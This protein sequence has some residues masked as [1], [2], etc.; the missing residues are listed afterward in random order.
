MKPLA[1]K[2]IM[3]LCGTGAAGPAPAAAAAATGSPAA[4]AWLLLLVTSYSAIHIE[5]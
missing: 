2:V 3:W 4:R 5:K 1:Q